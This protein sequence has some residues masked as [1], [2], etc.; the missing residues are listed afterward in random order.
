M[1]VP[2]RLAERVKELKLGLMPPHPTQR[3]WIVD[4]P[5]QSPPPWTNPGPVQFVQLNRKP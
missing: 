2:Q 5:L 4:A 1:Q 3:V